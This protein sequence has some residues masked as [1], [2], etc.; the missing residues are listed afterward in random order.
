MH[1]KMRLVSRESS[2][3]NDVGERL[4]KAE[5]GKGRLKS[6]RILRLPWKCR[7]MPLVLS[8]IPRLCGGVTNNSTTRV[9][10]GYRIYSLWRFIAAHITITDS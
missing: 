4:W 9:R 3:I 1:K 8:H 2:D 7:P 6:T 10:I 5:D